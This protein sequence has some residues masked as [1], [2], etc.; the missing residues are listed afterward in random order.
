MSEMNNSGPKKMHMEQRDASALELVV[1]AN[2]NFISFVFP[3]RK[4][5]CQSLSQGSPGYTCKR[6]TNQNVA[7]VIY[8]AKEST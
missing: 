4:S 6:E 2:F 5:S 3:I 7:G 1:D 8:G